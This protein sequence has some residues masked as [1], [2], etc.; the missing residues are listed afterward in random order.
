M[1]VA[2]FAEVFRSWWYWLLV[3][4]LMGAVFYTAG[5]HLSWFGPEELRWPAFWRVLRAPWAERMYQQGLT[6]IDERIRARGR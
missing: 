5:F 2:A 6:K 3:L 1:N 4:P